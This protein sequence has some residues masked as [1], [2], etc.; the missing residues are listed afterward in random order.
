MRLAPRLFRLL[1]WDGEE[2][3]HHYLEEVAVLDYELI[4]RTQE[5]YEAGR[6]AGIEIGMNEGYDLGFDAG[7]A[8]RGQDVGEAVGQSYEEGYI[9]GCMQTRFRIE[10]E[11]A[12]QG[13]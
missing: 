7:Y 11:L 5:A 1:W 2:V 12:P 10:R 3:I 9:E 8:I 6:L 4:E 13:A